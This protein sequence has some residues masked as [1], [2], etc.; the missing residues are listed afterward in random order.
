M[1]RKKTTKTKRD[2]F[3]RPN[4]H[5]SVYKLPGNRRRPWIARITS[6]WDEDSGRQLFQT[7]GYYKEEEEGEAALALHRVSPISPK[8]GISLGELYEEWS[9]GKYQYISR[10]TADNYKAAWKYLSKYKNEKIKDIRTAHLQGIIDGCHKDKMSRST[11]EKIRIV[12]VSLFN[13]AIENDIVNKNYA[14]FLHLPKTER[15]EKERFSDLE[16]KKMFDS[17]PKNEWITTVLIMIYTGLRITE[18]LLLTKFN[19]NLDKWIITGGIKTEAGKNRGIPINDKIKTYVKLWYDK[20]GQALI[21]HKEGKG[22][23]AK[24]YREEYYYPALEAAGVRKLVPHACRHTCASL[25]AEKGV[26]PIFIQKI[27][28]HAKYATAAEIYTHLEEEK[29][30]EAINKI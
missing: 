12:S 27:L 8:A 21:C 28:G 25:M 23:L 4:G 3:K 18:M 22:I 30:K 6:G 20:N 14:S 9:A 5:G 2:D 19:V 10:Q 7:I 17:T 29:L 11:L 16:I 24:Y 26:D 13:Y 15:I 1:P